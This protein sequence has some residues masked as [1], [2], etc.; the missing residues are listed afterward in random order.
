MQQELEGFCLLWFPQ[1]W[2]HLFSFHC[3]GGNQPRALTAE[4]ETQNFA[5]WTL[6]CL[7]YLS[8]WFKKYP[9]APA[10]PPNASICFSGTVLHKYR[11]GLSLTFPASPRLHVSAWPENQLWKTRC[12]FNYLKDS[13][14]KQPDLVSSL[15]WTEKYT[16]LC[17][18]DKSRTF[19]ACKMLFLNPTDASWLDTI[20]TLGWDCVLAEINALETE[21]KQK[22]AD[23]HCRTVVN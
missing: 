9:R 11:N 7:G 6:W 15:F 12:F 22:S 20:H 10:W 14:D 19:S 2:E 23:V 4:G 21:T 13:E 17:C 3:R 18:P 16:L 8:L 5:S 1:P